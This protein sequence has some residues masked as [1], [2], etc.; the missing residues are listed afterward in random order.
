MKI[1]AL[2]PCLIAFFFFACPVVTSP[3]GDT[4]VVGNA[5][6]VEVRLHNTDDFASLYVNGVKRV[7]IGH[8]Q[9]SRKIRVDSFMVNGSNSLRFVTQ[10]QGDATSGGGS[11]YGHQI[12]VNDQLVHDEKCGQVGVQG[13]NNNQSYVG[14]VILDRT[15]KVDVTGSTNSNQTVMVSSFIPGRI[16]LNG[17][18]TGK[19]TPATLSLTN[20]IYRIGFGGSNNRYQE[21][22]VNVANQKSVNFQ[23]SGWMAAKPWKILLLSTRNTYLGSGTGGNQTASLTNADI[24]TAYNELLE[25]NRRWVEPFSY[26]LA[27]W[28]VEQR[29][30]ENVTAKI[31]DT[32]DHINFNQFLQEAGLTNLPNQYDAVV[33]FWGRIPVNTDPWG[34]AGAVGGG[35]LMS[36][37]NTWIRGQHNF[38]S[39][40]WLHEWLHVAEGASSDRRHN[41]NGIGGLHGAEEHGFRSGV[42]GEWLDWYREFM[43]GTVTEG[44]LFVGIPPAVWL[45]GSRLTP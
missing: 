15:F 25:T 5:T 34:G 30:I 26:G 14:G 19:T 27:S 37:P 28:T 40:V 6:K 29:T 22:T 8:G 36:V 12:W 4:P 41:F 7:G 20:G 17:E 44:D 24:Q 39:E 38:P 16:F 18:F 10:N 3:S 33:Y 43:R 32:G 1:Q 42:E 11:T 21:N 23:D 45:A 35:S 9:D 13:C 31:T 2:F